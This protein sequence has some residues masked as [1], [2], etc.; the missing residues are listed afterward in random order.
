MVNFG[1]CR[2]KPFPPNYYICKNC[3]KV[4]HKSCVQQNKNKYKFL[5]DFQILCCNLD[6]KND[7][8]EKSLLE[9]TIGELSEN[10]EMQNKHIEKLKRENK[11]FLKEVAMREEELNEL[12]KK[13]QESIRN[14]EAEI[15]ELRH[16]IDELTNKTIKTI[17]TQTEGKKTISLATQT[18]EGVNY[19]EKADKLERD[20][21]ELNIL[22]RNM[23]TSIC[24]LEAEN[25]LYREE[26]DALREKIYSLNSKGQQRR[27]ERRIITHEE[28][29][30][31]I[32][33]VSNSRGRN[34]GMYFRKLLGDNHT[35]E[36]IVKPN[37]DNRE[38]TC[39]AQQNALHLNENDT[40][41]LWPSESSS[42]LVETFLIPLENTQRIIITQPYFSSFHKV[43]DRIYKNNLKLS[44]AAHL[45]KLG[46]CLF[47]CN[48]F[49]R[50]NNYKGGK[51]LNETGKWFI[52]KAIINYIKMNPKIKQKTSHFKKTITVGVKMR[53]KTKDAIMP[54][55]QMSYAFLHAKT[56]KVCNKYI[57][58]TKDVQTIS[59][60]PEETQNC[61]SNEADSNRFLY[62]QQPIETIKT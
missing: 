37:A 7:E 6:S 36:S 35:V 16:K 53:K 41:I 38:L 31:K 17:S 32:L 5:K 24:T 60:T 28:R 23:I 42:D 29:Q 58:L 51:T 61:V 55:Q 57:N 27:E 11:Q 13:Q 48:N 46:D 19:E 3:L 44:K 45:A 43:N 8:D 18:I 56:N 21:A 39:T 40:V 1:C 14:Y 49:L 30:R 22:H 34:L 26:A 54:K 52:C 10:S 12:L 47:E 50:K 4:F 15:I 20:V 33:I 62:L 2:T 25:T 9:Q 59:N